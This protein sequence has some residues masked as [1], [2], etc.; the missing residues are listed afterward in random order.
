LILNPRSAGC[1][2]WRLGIWIGDRGLRIE[3]QG[4]RIKD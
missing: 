4:S 1:A 3:D 2:D